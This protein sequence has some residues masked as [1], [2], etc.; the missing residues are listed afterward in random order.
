MALT[1]LQIK[2]AKEG[3]HSDGGGLYLQVSKAGTKS[4]IFR[5]QIDGRRREMGLG[6]LADKSAIKAR[7]E[8]PALRAQL[9]VK[10]DPLELKRIAR[11][12]SQAEA[13]KADLH[14]TTFRTAASEYILKNRSGWSNDHHAWQWQNS[15]ELYAFP[16]FGDLPAQLVSTEDVLAALTPIWETKTETATRVR[17][18][19]ESILDYAKVKGYRTDD[20]P[21]RWRGH[22][23]H[24]LPKPSSVRAVKHQPAVPFKR[25]GEFMQDLRPR[26]GSGAS[27][28]EFAIL[29]A[30]RSG[31][32]RGARWGEIDL[33]ERVWTVPAERMKGRKDHLVP[34][35][36]R[37]VQIL[38]GIP[39]VAGQ[40][41]IFAGQ[42]LDA[43]LSDRTL[44]AV[45]I[46]I[47]KDRRAANEPEW[48]D[49]KTNVT[50]VPHG[51][52]SSFRDWAA[53]VTDYPN[54]MG[55][56]ALAHAVGDKV[57]AAYRRGSMFEKRR[58][59]MEDWAAW[60]DSKSTGVLVPLLAN[61]A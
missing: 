24:I 27:A 34:L 60:C 21:A 4:W 22:L 49:A 42:K 61:A 28:L 58:R 14:L 7:A 18:R 54:E 26:E 37:A 20:N 47:N 9:A 15:L 45:V 5:Y 53:E 6:G 48:V 35:S 2:H 52:R 11:A 44:L 29:T 13:E 55:E 50:V 23:E 36:G 32:V 41:L 16:T 19:I 3:M 59:M 39:R 38:Q 12:D 43:P 31:E 25:M 57:E 17:Q 56:L 33:V 1:A 30:S 51:F 8:I 40:D 10:C 46:R